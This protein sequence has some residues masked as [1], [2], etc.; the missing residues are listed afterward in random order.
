M[1]KMVFWLIAALFAA[2]VM[3][4]PVYAVAYVIGG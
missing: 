3:I 4:V 1:I 2:M